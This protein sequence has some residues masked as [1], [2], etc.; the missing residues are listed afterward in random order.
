MNVLNIYDCFN[1]LVHDEKSD[2]QTLKVIDDA[3]SFIIAEL[4]PEK[5]LGAHYHMNGTEL[6]H[7][8]EGEGTMEI[9][10]FTDG[11]VQWEEHC[12]LK[13]GDVFEILPNVIHKLTNT[14]KHTLKLV[15]L[16]P[17]SH[18]ADDRTFI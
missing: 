5:K 18:L 17:P 6:Y 4:K 2:I 13:A 1:T 10:A 16:T 11:E 3:M 14:S 9:G 12:L 8:L 7:V 15:F